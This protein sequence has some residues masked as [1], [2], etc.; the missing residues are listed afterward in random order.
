[1]SGPVSGRH[2]LPLVLALDKPEGRRRPIGLDA[3]VDYLRLHL[4]GSARVELVPMNESMPVCEQVAWLQAADVVITPAGGIR[5]ESFEGILVGDTG[6]HPMA[7]SC[8]SSDNLSSCT[9]NGLQLKLVRSPT[10][11]WPSALYHTL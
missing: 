4:G 7:C 9:S 6:A 8:T 11:F 1:M 3:A 10:P 2:S 5:W